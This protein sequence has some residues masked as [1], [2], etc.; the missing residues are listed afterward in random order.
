L[1]SDFV[2]HPEPDKGLIGLRQA[3]TDTVSLAKHPAV[4]YKRVPICENYLA[5]FQI[6]RI[7]LILENTSEAFKLLY[8]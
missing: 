6:P 4:Q 8:D 7:F 3:Q 2:C 5:N 1:F